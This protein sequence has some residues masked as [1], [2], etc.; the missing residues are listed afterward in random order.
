MPQARTAQFDTYGDGNRPTDPLSYAVSRRDSRV[1]D[2]VEWALRNKNSKMAYQPVVQAKDTTRVAF[3]E[4]LTRLMDETGRMIPAKDFM[5]VVEDTELG[6]MID[7]RALEQGL[8][9][10][11]IE[12]QLRLSINMSARSIGYKPWMN[13]LDEGLYKHEHIAKRLILEITESS[14]MTMP[15]L[16][17]SFMADMH[18]K[19][20]SFAIDDFGAGQTSFRYLR[21]FFFDVLKIDGQYI[22]NLA[23]SPDNQILTEALVSISNHFEMFT[24]AECVET[25]QDAEI[26]KS[27][28]IDCLQGYHFGAPTIT[29]PWYKTQGAA[30]SERIKC[31]GAAGTGLYPLAKVPMAYLSVSSGHTRQKRR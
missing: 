1:L 11:K 29:P 27:L 4:G 10:L 24:V 28:G 6:R 21:D 2:L 15:E 23:N 7:V 22:R 25:A 8:E 30:D 26:L 14:A 12:P 18:E 5:P 13:A 31:R 3:F 9:M 17:I 16:V 20:I 19:G